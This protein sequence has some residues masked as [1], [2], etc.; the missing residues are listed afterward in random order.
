MSRP[1]QSLHLRE[2]FVLT[3]SG[4]HGSMRHGFETHILAACLPEDRLEVPNLILFDGAGVEFLMHSGA[5]TLS[6]RLQ[7]SL[8]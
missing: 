4:L 5:F 1:G 6:S 8:V 2:S 7:A 3:A